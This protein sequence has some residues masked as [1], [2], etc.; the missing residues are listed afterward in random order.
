MTEEQIQRKIR[1]DKTE[2]AMWSGRMDQ[3]EIDWKKA[4]ISE[5]EVMLPQ[6]RHQDKVF[7]LGWKSIEKNA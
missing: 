4:R 3:S 6:A 7:A 1:L 5:L 2:L